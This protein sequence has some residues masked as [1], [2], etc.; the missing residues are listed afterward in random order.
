MH[1]AISLAVMTQELLEHLEGA[2]FFFSWRLLME[3][4]FLKLDE[5]GG[6]GHS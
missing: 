3:Q 2:R 1:Q 5:F 4:Q 6:S